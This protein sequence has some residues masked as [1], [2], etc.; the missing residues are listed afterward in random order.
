MFTGIIE[1]LGVVCGISQGA[2]SVKLS[3]KTAL[4]Q[5]AEIGDS[6]AVNGVCLTIEEKEAGMVT[7]HVLHE[8]MSRSN[9]GKLK[10]GMAVNLESAMRL[11][12][13]LG[14][15]IVSGHIDCCGN[16][17][18]IQKRTGDIALTIARPDPNLF[19]LVPKGSIAINGVSLTVAELTAEKV[20]VCLIPHT[21]DFTNLHL[22]K[23]GSQVNLEADIIGK[24]VMELHEPYHKSTINLDMLKQAGF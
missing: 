10:S 6:I 18:A 13:K 7:F 21:W 1:D 8:T 14:G 24:Y 20:T 2:G 12:G 22:L 23:A 5:D 9:L 17:L 3:V 4:T 11:G 19:P 15:H 16:V